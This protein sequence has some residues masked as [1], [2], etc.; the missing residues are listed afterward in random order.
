MINV[1]RGLPGF[2]RLSDPALE[3]I[4]ARSS[5][6]QFLPG[7]IIL[8]GGFVPDRLYC[9]VEGAAEGI[10]GM[11]VFDVPGLLFGLAT[12]EDVL[13]GPAGLSAVVIAKPHLFTIVRE[14]PE[15]IVSI[16]HHAEAKG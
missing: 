13:A 4:I 1:F 5:L 16:L 11:T 12:S 6:R 9:C 14:F 3:L 10:D 8:P 7:Q 2:D 15:F